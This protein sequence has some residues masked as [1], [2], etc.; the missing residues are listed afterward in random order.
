MSK[1]KNI[2]I[3][4]VDLGTNNLIIRVND[5]IVYD[6]PSA[7]VFDIES[8]QV[9]IGAEALAMRGRTPSNKI[10]KSPL[11]NGVI[12]DVNSLIALLIEIFVNIVQV[13]NR[14][15]W[16]QRNFW[17]NSVVLVGIPSKIYRLDEEV[18]SDALRG[19]HVPQIPLFSEKHKKYELFSEVMKAEKVVI[20]PNVK[21][22]SIG[23]G[24]PIWDTKGIFILDIGGGTADSAI[25]SL[26]DIII[27]D[28]TTSAGNSI[29]HAIHTYLEDKHYISV[30]P[31]ETEEIKKIVG[32][33][34]IGEGTIEYIESPET[35]IEVYGKS[36]KTGNPDKIIIEKTEIES[37][38][39]IAMQPIVDLCFSIIQ[40]AGTVFSRTIQNDGLYVTGGGALTKNLD[41]YL[42][43][44]LK[45]RNVWIANDPDKCTIY[46]TEIFE[47]HKNDLFEKGFIRPSR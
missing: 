38:I 36:L 17:K 13:H 31:E 26:G 19:R 32:L 34:K 4:S 21:L 33:P 46:G 40:R 15:I 47:L 44:K 11:V 41:Q 27:E 1:N 22:A 14:K 16:K 3:I 39:D 23:A 9:F 25:I 42:M 2:N 35:T 7:I 28:S 37:I 24:L 29:D 5:Q 30:T 8:G 18:I 45:I 20:M 43:E 12:S 6:Q 10:F